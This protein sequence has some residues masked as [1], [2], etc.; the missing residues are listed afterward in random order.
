MD[1]IDRMGRGASGDRTVGGKHD[2][3]TEVRGRVNATTTDSGLDEWFA[4]EVQPRLRGRAFL[5]RY[6]DDFVIGFADERDARRVME[7]LPKRLGKYGLTLHPEKTRLVPFRRPARRVTGKD[8]S[9]EDWPGTFDLLGFTHYWGRSRKGSWVVKRKT[10]P[11]RFTRALRAIGQW[12]RR[13]RHQPICE[14]HPTLRQK[15]RGHYAYYGITGNSIALARFREEVKRIW[16]KWLCRRKR[17][18]PALVSYGK[19]AGTQRPEDAAQRRHH[20]SGGE[21]TFWSKAR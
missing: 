17:G 21:S 8:A 3:D 11:T 13:H 10:A 5:I 16:R 9:D 15:L 6:A 12:C 7:V 1:G 19:G 20:S 14:Q 18:R 2:E 4:Q